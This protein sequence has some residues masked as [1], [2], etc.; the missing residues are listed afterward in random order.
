MMLYRLADKKQ[1][2]ITQFR[3]VTINYARD[4][5]RRNPLGN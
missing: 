3:D 5:L 1:Q 2:L 4:R